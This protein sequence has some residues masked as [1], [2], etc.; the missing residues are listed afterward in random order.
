M[1]VKPNK[2]DEITNELFSLADKIKKSNINI[3]F[4]KKYHNY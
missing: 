3:K 4:Y 2:A 1:R